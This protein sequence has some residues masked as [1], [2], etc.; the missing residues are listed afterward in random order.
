MS[1]ARDPIVGGPQRTVAEQTAYRQLKRLGIG[2]FSAHKN[3]DQLNIPNGPTLIT[4]NDA[5]YNPSN[6]YSIATSR[7]TPKQRGYYR[8]NC[9]IFLDAGIATK[10]VSLILY[11]NGSSYKIL[12]HRQMARTDDFLIAGTGIAKSDGDDY[13]DIYME[14]DGAPTT[15]DITAPVSTEESNFFEGELI[16]EYGS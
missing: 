15:L 9:Q 1:I 8:F 12:D 4:F 11:K 14:H 3:V 5:E 7:Y 10:H 2:T 6:W 13:W 16:S